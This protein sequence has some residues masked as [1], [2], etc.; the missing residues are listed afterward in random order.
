[1][2]NGNFSGGFYTFGTQPHFST[3]YYFTCPEGGCQEVF[4]NFFII[5][6]LFS[7]FCSFI[8][9]KELNFSQGIF[10]RP[11][12]T[13]DPVYIFCSEF[14]APRRRLGGK[15]NLGRPKM[16]FIL[17]LRFLRREV[18]AH[19]CVRPRNITPFDFCSEKI[20]LRKLNLGHPKMGFILKLRFLRLCRGDHWSPVN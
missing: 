11:R 18:G 20:A 8:S 3:F 7:R 15:L 10:F 2:S 9:L 16:G 1:M 4:C 6:A 13:P 19:P 5:L 14:F 17:K 12:A